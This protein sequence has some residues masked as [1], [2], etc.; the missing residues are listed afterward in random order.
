MDKLQVYT[1]GF[2]QK[3]AEVFF[4]LL[5]NSGAKRIVDVRLN[6]TS[7]LAGFAKQDDLKYIAKLHDIGYIYIP[8]L[9][10]T[11]EIRETITNRKKPE[12]DWPIYEKN[13]FKLMKERSIE[14]LMKSKIRDGDCLLCS[15][16]EPDYCHR[17]LVIEYLNKKW[18]DSISVEH[19]M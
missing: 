11:K 19:L 14:E 3:N 5:K 10:P 9:A 13:F 2:T 18:G 16:H 1:I 7:Q 15:E 4:T 8:E 17:R 12:K 6:N